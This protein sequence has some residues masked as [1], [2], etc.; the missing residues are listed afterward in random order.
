MIVPIRVHVGLLALA[1]KY[2]SRWSA[3]GVVQAQTVALTVTVV[4]W[5]S[6]PLELE[7]TMRSFD[8][9]EWK[10]PELPSAQELLMVFG[11]LVSFPPLIVPR[12][13]SS[14]GPESHDVPTV[15]HFGALSVESNTAVCAPPTGLTVRLIVV[16]CVSV[17]DVPVMVIVLV[18]VV[19]VA[20][21][22]RVRVEVTLP[23]AGG[24]TGLGENAA[25]TPVGKPEA[26]RLVAELKLLT[27]VIVTVL[28]PFVP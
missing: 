7:T 19:A 27:L 9:S 17:P 2:R 6:R 1:A 14:V 4:P 18:P 20:D 8:S 10:V 26:A 5:V 21:A 13:R 12:P 23:F 16:L 28:V 25:V 11:R 3:D 22:V 15:P 24:V